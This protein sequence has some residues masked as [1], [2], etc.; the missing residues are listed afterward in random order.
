[1]VI[2]RTLPTNKLDLDGEIL[3]PHDLEMEIL[4]VSCDNKP[5]CE[6]QIKKTCIP[7]TH[8]MAFGCKWKGTSFLQ[9]LH[10]LCDGIYSSDMGSSCLEILDRIQSRAVNII[11]G[12]DPGLQAPIRF[13][14]PE[15]RSG[16]HHRVGNTSATCDAA[17]A[18]PAKSAGRTRAVM[19]QD[20]AAPKIVH[21][22]VL[23]FQVVF[24]NMLNI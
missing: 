24:P 20:M 11:S 3:L 22:K 14:A 12:G 21:S 19:L 4:G 8:F 9:S 23:L 2:T 1:M 10:S 7:E 16:S 17:P 5:T 13:P 6:T 15:G 18:R